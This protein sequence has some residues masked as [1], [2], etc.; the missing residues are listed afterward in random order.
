M[1]MQNGIHP[2]TEVYTRSKNNTALKYTKFLRILY[3]YIPNFL[4]QNFI[5]LKSDICLISKYFLLE[6]E[7]ILMLINLLI[8]L[9]KSLHIIPIAMKLQRRNI[10]YLN[11]Y[12]QF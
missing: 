6:K 8:F 1:H 11:H 5:L 2:V 12:R 4:K 9:I 7:K 3:L 10:K